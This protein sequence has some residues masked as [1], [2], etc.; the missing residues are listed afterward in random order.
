MVSA[1]SMVSAKPEISNSD[2]LARAVARAALD[3]GVLG[4]PSQF[5]GNF[6]SFSASAQRPNRRIEHGYRAEGLAGLDHLHH[7]Q[8]KAAG[9]TF[10][11]KGHQNQTGSTGHI[12]LVSRLTGLLIKAIGLVK[13]LA[14]M[15][16]PLVTTAGC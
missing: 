6:S 9:T 12:S 15:V 11:I 4:A 7:L 5:S 8:T 3:S 2:V 1:S 10:T 14:A 16:S 13:K